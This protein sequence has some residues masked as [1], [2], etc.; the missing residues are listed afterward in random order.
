MPPS[1]NIKVYRGL[2]LRVYLEV[3]KYAEILNFHPYSASYCGVL[4]DTKLHNTPY[5][6]LA[7]WVEH[8]DITSVHLHVPSMLEIGEEVY[9]RHVVA[10]EVAHCFAM[11]QGDYT[12]GYIW[13]KMMDILNVPALVTFEEI[14]DFIAKESR[15]SLV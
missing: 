5:Q 6:G 14:K 13:K 10:H 12:H 7:G 2:F 15:D 4:I 8:K 1:T 9:C 3:Q 11:I